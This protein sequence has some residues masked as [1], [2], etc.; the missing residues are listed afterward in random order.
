MVQ[1]CVRTGRRVRIKGKVKG[2][3]YRYIPEENL[4]KTSPDLSVYLAEVL[5]RGTLE[6]PQNPGVAKLLVP[7]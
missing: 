3:T 2:S 5:Q 6:D 7:Q 1:G 4:L